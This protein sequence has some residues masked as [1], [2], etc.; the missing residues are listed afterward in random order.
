[1]H[2]R[3]PRTEDG[4]MAAVRLPNK[5]WTRRQALRA[6]LGAA[7]AAAALAACAAPMSPTK[8]AA[9]PPAAPAKM[10]T[11][12]PAAGT[13][14]ARLYVVYPPTSDEDRRI[15]QILF[16]AFEHT[17]NGD[18]TIQYDDVAGQDVDQKVTT[19]LAGGGQ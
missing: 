6:M 18:I 3:F 15:F 16:D 5:A 12:R 14:K 7:S 11:P 9:T 10:E 17:T 4:R 2:S 19:I 13:G 1:M 8:P